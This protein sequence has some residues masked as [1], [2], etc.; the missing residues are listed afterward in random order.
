MSTIVMENW[1]KFTQK[2]LTMEELRALK[3][4]LVYF[5][6]KKHIDVSEMMPYVDAALTSAPSLEGFYGNDEL[7]MDDEDEGD[8]GEEAEEEG[9]EADEDEGDEGEEE[10]EEE[11]DQPNKKPKNEEV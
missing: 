2:R 10:E 6:E 11:E 9:D 5:E 1:R 7:S 8:E 4:G 3:E